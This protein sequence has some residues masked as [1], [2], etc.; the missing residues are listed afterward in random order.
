MGSQLVCPGPEPPDEGPLLGLAFCAMI[1]QPPDFV[2]SRPAMWVC[3][4]FAA[5]GNSGPWLQRPNKS[6]L[7]GLGVKGHE[8]LDK[9]WSCLVPR[10]QSTL[11]PAGRDRVKL[12]QADYLC[13]PPHA[14]ALHKISLCLQRSFW[15]V[16]LLEAHLDEEDL[17]V[18][19]S[20]PEQ[21]CRG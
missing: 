15:A 6:M 1:K 19:L 4:G 10:C 9:A 13:M 12:H 18:Q 20:S 17:Q 21:S 2:V 8:A 11:F 5:P 7:G 16:D 14:P 3:V